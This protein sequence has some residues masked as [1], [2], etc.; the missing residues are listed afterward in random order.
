[1]ADPRVALGGEEGEYLEK[2]TEKE[3]KRFATIQRRHAREL[4][5]TKQMMEVRVSLETTRQMDPSS[6]R[7]DTA[8]GVSLT[9]DEK[10]IVQEHKER[11]EARES[12]G[13]EDALMEDAYKE[14]LIQEFRLMRYRH[15]HDKATERQATQQLVDARLDVQGERI[16]NRRDVY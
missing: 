7:F 3:N 5:H 2:W 16:D 11:L 14:R 10:R 1:M 9:E 4:E 12:Q 15:E 6:G 8:P 13:R